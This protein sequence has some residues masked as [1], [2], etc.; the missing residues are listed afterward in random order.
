MEFRIH[1]IRNWQKAD[2]KTSAFSINTG[3]MCNDL[4]LV[5]F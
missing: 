5:F 2:A 3:I 4:G 1:G